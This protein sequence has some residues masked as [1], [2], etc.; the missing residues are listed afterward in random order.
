VRSSKKPQNLG[1]LAPL[2]AGMWGHAKHGARKSLGTFCETVQRCSPLFTPS[3][4]GFPPF[5]HRHRPPLAP[6]LHGHAHLGTAGTRIALVRGSPPLLALWQLPHP[7]ASGRHHSM[8]ASTRLLL[9]RLITAGARDARLQ[10]PKGGIRKKMTPGELTACRNTKVPK[11]LSRLRKIRSRAF[12]L[13]R[14]ATSSASCSCSSLAVTTS[15]PASRS[16]W[17]VMK[18]TS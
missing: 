16:S 12:A 3:V 9:V 17:T 6:Q 11:S 1:L 18:Y 7:I 4:F 13:A 8:N 5:L 2:L 15:C 14:R 10:L